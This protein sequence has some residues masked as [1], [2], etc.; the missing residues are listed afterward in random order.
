MTAAELAADI[1]SLGPDH[2][3][4]VHEMRMIRKA[5]DGRIK[6]GPLDLATDSRDFMAEAMAEGLDREWY[7]LMEIVKLRRENRELLAKLGTEHV[8]RGLAELVSAPAQ[9]NDSLGFQ[10]PDGNGESP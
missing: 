7:L 2:R 6:Y 4:A 1:L 10:H 5:K 8:E 9:S 3:D